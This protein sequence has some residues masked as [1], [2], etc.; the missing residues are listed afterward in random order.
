MTPLALF[1]EPFA[2]S[3]NLAAEGFRKLLGRPAL[4]LLQTVLREAIQNSVDASTSPDGCEVLLRCRTL[5]GPQAEALRSVVFAGIP[6]EK[7][8]GAEMKKVLARQT[9][10]VFEVCDFGTRGLA[11]PTRADVAVRE[12]EVHDFVNFLRNVGAGRDTDQGGGTYGYGKTSLYAFSECSAIIADTLT[13]A[14]G[15]PVRRLMAC[16]LGAAFDARQSRRLK[17]FTGRHWWGAGQDDGTLEPVT[18]DAAKRISRLVGMPERPEGR[19]GTSVLIVAPCIDAET[20]PKLAEEIVET[21]LWNFWPRMTQTTPAVRRLKIRLEI[22]GQTVVVPAPE[23]FPP[24]DLFCQAMNMHR[25]GD[26]ALQAIMSVR[27]GKDLGRLAIAKGI[28]APRRSAAGI[29]PEQASHI[30]LMRPVEL[31]VKYLPGQPYPDRRYEWAGV[32]ICSAEPEVEEAFAASEPPAHDDWL[33][34]MLPDSWPKRWVNIAL[35]RLKQEAA[36]VVNPGGTITAEGVHDMPVAELAVRMGRLL[37][38]TASGRSREQGAQ[39]QRRAGVRFLSRP[40]FVGLRLNGDQRPVA[41]FEAD[42]QNDG[43]DNGLVVRA[44]AVLSVEGA[45]TEASDL[46]PAFSPEVATISLGG[47]AG[48]RNWIVAGVESGIIQVEVTTIPAAAV[49]VRLSVLS[50]G[51]H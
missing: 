27:P 10:R 22:E 1:S 39:G 30:A 13:V 21:V 51:A 8:T 4:G 9:L 36:N 48:E 43:K 25:N 50:G 28:S 38:G 35:G 18:G 5:I 16:H 7:G 34:K 15:R 12:G 44:E 6:D 40:R 11:G 47:R 33:P 23:H 31:V 32:F 41:V 26:E 37:A 19:T 29:L 42:L 20:E 2:H 45:T 49:S 3:G 24:L 14:R 46:P 17:R